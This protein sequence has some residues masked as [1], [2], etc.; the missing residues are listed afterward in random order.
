[1]IKIIKKILTLSLL[2]AVTTS[3]SMAFL[4][5]QE[6]ALNGNKTIVINGVVSDVVTNS[7]IPDMKITFSAYGENS[8]SVMPLV[9]TVTTT[10]DNGIYTVE[11]F[12]FSDPVTCT[13]TAESTDETA[14]E[15]ETLTNKI[16]VTWSGTSYEAYTRTF[17][18]ND[19]NF[20]MKKN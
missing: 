6:A 7:P 18:V 12:G 10:D 4:G 13:V 2:T 14:N 16:V 17:Y 19:C 9:S 15:Y 1:M 3:C 20:Q 11:V 8:L 5:D